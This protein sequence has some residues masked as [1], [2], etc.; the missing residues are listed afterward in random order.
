MILTSDED[1]ALREVLLARGARA[2]LGKPI[3]PARLSGVLESIL[4]QR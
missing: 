4:G 2:W 3:D 1:P